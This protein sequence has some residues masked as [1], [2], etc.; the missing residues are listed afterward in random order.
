VSSGA[1][2]SVVIGRHPRVLR[3]GRRR[4][5]GSQRLLR[6]HAAPA[7]PGGQPADATAGAVPGWAGHG[8]GPCERAALARQLRDNPNPSASIGAWPMQHRIEASLAWPVLILTMAAPLASR[9]FQ[10]R[11]TE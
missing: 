6:R 4:R 8:P 2:A 10:R 1:H 7:G 3:A 11:T 5:P 9:N